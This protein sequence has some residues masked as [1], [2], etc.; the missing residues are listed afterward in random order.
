MAAEPVQRPRHAAPRLPPAVP[1]QA[2]PPA[3]DL[4]DPLFAFSPTYHTGSG[5]SSLSCG[6]GPWALRTVRYYSWHLCLNTSGS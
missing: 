4:G 5:D 1:I 2:A 6:F 3:Q